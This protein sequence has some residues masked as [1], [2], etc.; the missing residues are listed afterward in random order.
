MRVCMCVRPVPPKKVN[1]KSLPLFIKPQ[2]I[3]LAHG[4]PPN[5]INLLSCESSQQHCQYLIS[6]ATDKIGS[7]YSM[8]FTSAQSHR[9]RDLTATVCGLPDLPSLSVA[10]SL[11]HSSFCFPLSILLFF[12]CTYTERAHPPQ[13][14][15]I[16]TVSCG[17]MASFPQTEI[18]RRQR[19]TGEKLIF[20]IT[21]CPQRA[22]PGPR[23]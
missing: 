22:R 3:Q 5:P 18:R 6:P 12:S 19:L 7:R 16:R 17:G 2:Q 8:G 20:L 11:A 10:C 4:L 9:C 1:K 23:D 21:A 14:K 13:K 15:S